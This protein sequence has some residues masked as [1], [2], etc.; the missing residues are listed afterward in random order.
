MS[1]HQDNFEIYM[2]P[3]CDIPVI[4]GGVLLSF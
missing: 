1:D 2:Q 3:T 4:Q